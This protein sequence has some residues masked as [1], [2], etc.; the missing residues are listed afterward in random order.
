[1]GVGWVE[2]IYIYIYTHHYPSLP[3]NG[4]NTVGLEKDLGSSLPP[5]EQNRVKVNI[6]VFL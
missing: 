1:M 5:E 3:I 4:L 2:E 6:Y